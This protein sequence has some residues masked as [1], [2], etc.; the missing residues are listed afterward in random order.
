MSVT[1]NKPVHCQAI[2]TY[3]GWSINGFRF[4]CSAKTALFLFI[5]FVLTGSLV[6]HLNNNLI[7]QLSRAGY[8]V[9]FNTS[10]ALPLLCHPATRFSYLVTIYNCPR[11]KSPLYSFLGS[12][13]TPVKP[14]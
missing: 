3:S 10:L 7:Y 13:T 4:P 2:N 11:A 1:G 5:S 12:N 8:A 6:C 9:P 14:G